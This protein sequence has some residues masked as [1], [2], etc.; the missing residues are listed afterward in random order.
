MLDKIDLSAR[1]LIEAVLD[2]DGLDRGETVRSEE[3]CA[4]LEV[5][6]E[7]VVPHGLDHLDGYELVE[8]ARQLTIVLEEDGHAV[9]EPGLTKPLVGQRMLLP[10]DRRGRDP[11]TVCPRRVQREASPAGPDLDHVIVWTDIEL[12]TE[13]VV[14]REGR[15]LQRRTR[16]IEDPC[17]VRHRLVEKFLEELV[18]EVVMRMDVAATSG[19]GIAIPCVQELPDWLYQ[20]GQPGLH[21]VQDVTIANEET[22]DCRQVR[23]G[24]RSVGVRLRGAHM[25]TES[26][27]AVEV[28]IQHGHG[29]IESLSCA[30]HGGLVA[31]D[32]GQPTILQRFELCPDGLLCH[33]IKDTHQIRSPRSA[34][35]GMNEERYPLEPQ[36]KCLPVDTGDHANGH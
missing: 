12:P 9:C 20:S 29:C 10:R 8:G 3:V 26:D 28:L 4:L 32:H 14:L 5:R 34:F 15:V 23:G 2:R 35:G 21:A 30:V 24:P 18:P 17:R 11:T 16:L 25:P 33:G 31:V 1:R 27:R 7:V 36:A 6:L 13:T 19:L 22:D